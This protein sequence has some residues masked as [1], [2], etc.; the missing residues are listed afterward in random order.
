[1]SRAF[2]SHLPNA[3]NR[4]GLDALL[5]ASDKGQALS[6]EE[7]LMEVARALDCVFELGDGAASELPSLWRDLVDDYAKS[8]CGLHGAD[9]ALRVFYAIMLCMAAMPYRDRYYRGELLSHLWRMLRDLHV[10]SGAAT[11]LTV[12]ELDNKHAADGSYDEPLRQWLDS[13]LGTPESLLEEIDQL[14][15][16]DDYP[17][18]KPVPTIALT[19][20]AEK[21]REELAKY[22]FE[23]LPKVAPLS[24]KAKSLLYERM[25]E[26]AAFGTAMLDELGLH[27]HL[28]KSYG[29]TNPQLEQ[30]CSAA[31]GGSSA[32]YKKYYASLTS[33]NPES[34]KHQNAYKHKSA[35]VDYIN[36]L[37]NASTLSN[38]T[39]PAS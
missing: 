18:L 23:E 29:L 8:D 10:V 19:T 38:D 15:H 1:M 5:P 6:A 4:Q 13:Y 37:M 20:R 26:N 2:D 32:T 28:K 7:L 33:G 11:S 36:E 16:P 12:A 27:E 34:Y 9:V 3:A 17:K 35:A 30:A 39:L 21:C 24:D 31:L 22:R 14:L 25:T